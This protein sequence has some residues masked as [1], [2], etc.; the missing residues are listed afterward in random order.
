ML[1]IIF[2]IAG[3]IYFDSFGAAVLCYIIGSII[4]SLFSSKS[5]EKKYEAARQRQQ[6]FMHDLLILTAAVMKAD[7]H[8]Y[9]VELNYVKGFFLQN[10]GPDNTAEALRD[11]REILKEDHDLSAVCRSFSKKSSSAELLLMLRFLFGLANADGQISDEELRTIKFI[12]DNC[13]IP[14]MHYESVKAMYVGGGSYSYGSGRS[15]QNR[16]SSSSSSSKYSGSLAND[17][18]ILEVSPD[19]TD[20]EVKKSYRRLAKEHHPDKVAHLGEN[21]MKAA[22]EKFKKLNEAYERIKVARGMR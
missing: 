20:D 16:Q 22:E 18:K 17:Y 9:K 1:R 11:L 3:Y 15:S 2:A 14:Y 6:N 19:A 21:M 12:S 8:L 5:E 7:G 4:E 13:G 10:F